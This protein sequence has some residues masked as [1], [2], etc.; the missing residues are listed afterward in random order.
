MLVFVVVVVII[1]WWV[2]DVEVVLGGGGD[3]VDDGV[4][5]I[6]VFWLCDSCWLFFMCV[7][8]DVVV[9]VVD[10]LICMNC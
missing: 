2:V 9:L 6:D 8:I 3:V 1:G 7:D 10:V 4:L 5:V